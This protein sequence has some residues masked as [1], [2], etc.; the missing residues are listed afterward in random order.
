MFNAYCIEHKIILEQK[1]NKG[2]Y[3]WKKM[4]VNNYISQHKTRRSR[5][6]QRHMFL[7]TLVAMIALMAL[8]GAV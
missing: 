6:R 5:I 3:G 4:I 2:Q 7:G 8:Y 1:K